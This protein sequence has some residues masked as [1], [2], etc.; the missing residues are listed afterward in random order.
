[1]SSSKKFNT[2]EWRKLSNRV[3]REEPTCRIRL[4]GCTGKSTTTDHII[5]RWLRPDLTMVRSNLRGACRQCNSA[6]G[7]KM[8]APAIPV[9]PAQVEAFFAGGAGGFAG[10]SNRTSVRR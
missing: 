6:L 7:N 4:P 9:E 2:W 3:I 5:P 1:M 10:R 8:R